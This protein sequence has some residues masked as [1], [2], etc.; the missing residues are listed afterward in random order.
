MTPSEVKQLLKAVYAANQD[1]KQ[2]HV[3]FLH[4]APGMAKSA[5]VADTATDL[6][7]GFMDYRISSKDLTDFTGVPEVVEHETYFAKP[8]HLPK[9]GKGIFFMDEFAQGTQ[10]LQSVSAQIL[11]DRMCGEYKFP[12]DW[13]IVVASNRGTDRAGTHPTPQQVN[14]RCTHIN[15]EMAFED[16]KEWA[17]AN[18]IDERLIY[19]LD[20]RQELLCQPSKDAE[21]FPTPRT[22]EF[23]SSIMQ[24]NL[25]QNIKSETIRGTVGDGP[26]Y[27]LMG[28]MQIFETIVPWRDVLKEP[29]TTPLPTNSSAKFALMGVLAKNVKF[30]TIDNL[31]LYLDRMPDQD[32][33]NMCIMTAGRRNKALLET[34]AYT[35]WCIARNI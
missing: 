15:M 18:E 10:N 30:D 6:G 1:R 35:N 11:Y 20:S 16:W 7:I 12:D 31:V 5:V 2:H 24:M 27:E 34:S 28:F 8:G 21:A 33:A 3:I 32:V 23:V 4:G 17:F 14:N 25:N 9:S 22:W 19:F 26:G 29:L 13:M